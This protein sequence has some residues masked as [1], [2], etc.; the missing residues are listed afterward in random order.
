MSLSIYSGDTPD[1]S[2]VLS[3]SRY[4]WQAGLV[5][6]CWQLVAIKVTF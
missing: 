4:N 3:R 1:A 2:D 6:L 5:R